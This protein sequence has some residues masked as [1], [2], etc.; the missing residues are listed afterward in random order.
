MSAAADTR[1]VA[2]EIEGAACHR[3]LEYACREAQARHSGLLLVRAYRPVV[4]YSPMT[5]MY[6]QADPRD[7]A[8]ADLRDAAEVA[9]T[10][11]PRERVEQMPMPMSRHS[12]LHAVSQDAQLLV[13]I[14]R[15]ARGP[16]R[17]VAAQS[18]LNLAGQAACP[19][20]AVPPG[21]TGAEAEPVYVGA[22]GTDLSVDA[23]EF[24]YATAAK[25]NCHLVVMHATG[26]PTTPGVPSL[27]EILERQT[28]GWPG[29]HVTRYLTSQ[30]ITDALIG[31]SSHAGLLVLGAH[32]GRLPHDPNARRAIAG[33]HCPIAIIK[34]I[35]T[36]TAD[37]RERSTALP[38][39]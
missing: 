24:A 34:H 27:A 8:L 14:R 32:A 30:S 7:D 9:H 1:P 31:V 20:I 29:V 12:A 11:L 15:H 6:V 23:I 3:V 19:V 18:T 13:V 16:H 22:D 37:N 33:A 39:H 21:W 26:S 5:P 36:E 2:V 10:R 35:P 25:R 28:A 38:R 17:T 4:S